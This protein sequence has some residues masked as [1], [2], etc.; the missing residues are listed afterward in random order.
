MK[1]VSLG[2]LM[3]ISLST[4][5]EKGGNISNPE[6]HKTTTMVYDGVT[7]QGQAICVAVNQDKITQISFGWICDDRGRP[8]SGMRG[9]SIAAITDGQFK[10]SRFGSTTWTVIGTL[11][12]NHEIIG[13]WSTDYSFNCPK[14]LSG[15]W[16][17]SLSES[18][19]TEADTMFVPVG[20]EWGLFRPLCGALPF[21]ILESP[22]PTI[23]AVTSTNLQVWQGRIRI[24][25]IAAG[26]TSITI[27]DYSSPS[28]TVTV[29]IA[30]N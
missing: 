23:A 24:K 17:A 11:T 7:D 9:D 2:I 18:L 8:R 4:G 15:T 20:S 21:D 30:V 29:H 12:A 22:D 19:I 10:I 13:T 6:N 26:N 28:L 5:C 14:A 1:Y 16:S 3:L 27:G 25:G